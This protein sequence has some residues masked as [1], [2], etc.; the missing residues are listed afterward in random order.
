MNKTG[1]R[2]GTHFQPMAPGGAVQ[3][4]S[5]DTKANARRKDLERVFHRVECR[6]SWINNQQCPESSV[7]SSPGAFCW[8]VSAVGRYFG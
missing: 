2:K 7:H 3:Q 6:E 1:L 5:L 4:S 8:N